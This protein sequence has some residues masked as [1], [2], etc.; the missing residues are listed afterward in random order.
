MV[1]VLQYPLNMARMAPQTACVSDLLADR[2]TEK[3]KRTQEKA[4]YN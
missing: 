3:L 1:N 4:L 2:H